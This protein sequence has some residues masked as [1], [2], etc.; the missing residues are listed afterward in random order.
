MAGAHRGR[1]RSWLELATS[2]GRR[3]GKKEVTAGG[4]VSLEVVTTQEFSLTQ[5]SQLQIFF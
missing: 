4:W 2:C 3:E 5:K 1:R